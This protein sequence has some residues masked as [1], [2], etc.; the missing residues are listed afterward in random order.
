MLPWH[1]D[2]STYFFPENFIWWTLALLRI[3]KLHVTVLLP[4]HN[5]WY[6]G[7]G[8]KAFFQIWRHSWWRHQMETFS[9]LLA[10]CAGNS[11]IPGEFPTQR[12][13]TRS[14]DGFFDLRLNKRLNKQPWGS[15]FETPSRSLWRQ[16]NVWLYFRVYRIPRS[17]TFHDP[18]MAQGFFNGDTLFGIRCQELP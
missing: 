18:G 12:P 11:P 5:K 16:C 8:L 17:P 15:W 14:F 6:L 4:W 13:V 2:N 9:T 7:F 1:M 10:I 3:D